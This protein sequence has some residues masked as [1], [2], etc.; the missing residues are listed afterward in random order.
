MFS[1]LVQ[2]ELLHHLL[3][4]RFVAVFA[5]CVLLSVLSVV[6]GCLNYVRQLQDYSATAEGHRQA[7]QPRLDKGN[8]YSFRIEGYRWSRRPEVLS[9]VVFGLAGKLGQEVQ[10]HTRRLPRFEASLFEEDPIYA[11]FG[12][13]D[14]AFV[15]KVV[16]S[17][18]VLLFTYDAIC[19]EKEGGTLRLY[20]SF[21]V[22]QSTLAMAKLA[23][24]TLAVLAPLV[25]AFLLAAAVLALYPEIDLGA[26]DW[27]RMAAV[28]VTFGLYLAV[29]GAFGLWV[30]AM[31]HRRMTAFLGLLGLW[32]VWIFIAP[33]VAVY[34][35]RYL[36]PT[37]RSVALQKQA[38]TLIIE[39]E[40]ARKKEVDG[41]FQRHVQGDWGDLT[42]ERQQ[43][44]RNGAQE[45]HER[46]DG[47]YA[48]GRTRMQEENRNRM[49]RQ[50]RLA[51]ALSAVSPLSAA[52]FVSMDLARNGFVQQERIEDALRPHL[53]YLTEYTR[54]KEG[55]GGRGIT[56]A[57][58]SDFSRFTYREK[59]PL[60]ACLSRN[61][62]HFLNL[63]LLVVVGFAGAYV[64]ILRYDVR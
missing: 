45:I 37:V 28:M 3:D 27:V 57:D 35:A 60:G 16:L 17:L 1:R 9:P 18:C 8:V 34:T 48:S 21:P 41:H 19:G 58:L 54:K 56:G 15:V 63:V 43:E 26:E 30:S 52:S 51:M 10:I 62:V 20:T 61:A 4:F 31:T 46:W 38:D 44:I 42:P 47:V 23:G 32:T 39:A 13:L 5:L 24:S 49:R 40:L 25:F 2:K 36:V 12:V 29:F 59:E 64:A 14:L 53:A 7:L 50:Q 11:L 55:E 6:V 22:A 33:G